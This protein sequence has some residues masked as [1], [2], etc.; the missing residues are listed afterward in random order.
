VVTW[1]WVF[2]M[3]FESRCVFSILGLS[4]GG[5]PDGAIDWERLVAPC[6]AC[7]KPV[8]GHRGFCHN[9]FEELLGC[10]HCADEH[11]RCVIKGVVQ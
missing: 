7:R 2:E 6:H 5:S 4:C 11:G 9:D 3:C 8:A 10:D 1:K